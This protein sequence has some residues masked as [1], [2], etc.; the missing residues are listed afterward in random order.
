MYSQIASPPTDVL[1][2][3]HSRQAWSE[4][5]ERWQAII[6]FVGAS[7]GVIQYRG[8]DGDLDDILVCSGTTEEEIWRG[9]VA[10]QDT[11]AL[12]RRTLTDTGHVRHFERDDEDAY[13]KLA[14]RVDDGFALVGFALPHSLARAAQARFETLVE[15]LQSA[16]SQARRDINRRTLRESLSILHAIPYAVL[17]VT[18]DASV[19]RMNDRARQTDILGSLLHTSGNITRFA[20]RDDGV[21]VRRSIAL[22]DDSSRESAP[23]LLGRGLRRPIYARLVR[24]GE[25]QSERFGLILPRE[26]NDGE[27]EVALSDVFGLTS[28]EARV[29]RALLS[30]GSVVGVSEALGQSREAVRFHLKNIYSKT[31]THSQAELVGLVAQSPALLV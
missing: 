31:G 22:L 27:L 23:C 26:S 19:V 18:R 4:W 8:E 6:A 16:L 12:I 1:N 17:T 11:D 21:A 30:A 20:D 9:S 29:A 24:L 3:L 25:Q 2:T 10:D 13:L 5:T 15:P 7:K 28:S 14:I